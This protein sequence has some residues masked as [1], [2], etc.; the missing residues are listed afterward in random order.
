[1]LI[2]SPALLCFVILAVFSCLCREARLGV[3]LSNLQGLFWL[4]DGQFV[5]GQDEPKVGYSSNQPRN[6]QGPALRRV[7]SEVQTLEAGSTFS[8]L[9]RPS[10]FSNSHALESAN[11][12]LGCKSSGNL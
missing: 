6:I 12:T 11:M 5:L 1:M 7:K 2:H 3:Y 9:L 10:G 4:G 8:S